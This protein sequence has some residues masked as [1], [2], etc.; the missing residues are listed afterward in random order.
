MR[1]R[2]IFFAAALFA[3]LVINPLDANSQTRKKK[4][5]KVV[6]TDE[7]LEHIARMKEM[8]LATQKVLFV[9]SVVVDKEKLL[10][11]LNLPSEAGTFTDTRKIINDN[12]TGVAFVT[13]LGDRCLFSALDQNK[14][15]RLF[16]S[17]KLDGEW[18]APQPLK[19]GSEISLD[20]MDYPFMMADGT[21]I[22]FAA[23]GGEGIG[24]YDLYVT[25]YNAED[26]T[27]YKPESLG[28]PFCSEANDYFYVVDEY[29]N[30]GWFATDRRQPEGKVCIYT[31]VPTELRDV[32]SY[33]IG[34][35][36]LKSLSQI[37]CIADTWGNGSERKAA[38]RRI[39]E[40]TTRLKQD[41]Q[42]NKS[43]M[44][45]VIN[46]NIVYT[47]P[48]QFRGEGNMA[49][50][51]EL[52]AA[53]QEY[54]ELMRNIAKSRSYFQRATESERETLRPEILA[55]E[56]QAETLELRIN[57]L[58]KEIRNAENKEILR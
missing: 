42:S 19:F 50:Y 24:G 32:Y 39:E 41:K 46:D 51:D 35:D 4:V 1:K 28:M 52:S 30:I 48:K 54:A 18:D 13:E 33:D 55:S 14:R 21:T 25:R 26:N 58:E 2:H 16:I 27:Y 12:S 37:Q 8:E 44:Q 9:D 53:R 7:E 20:D 34:S 6:L 45:F 3:A 56:Q 23:K 22:Y 43:E 17:D 49:R 10:S 40:L 57:Q 38:L 5:Q 47:N 31:F 29:D 15:S 36:K 11:V